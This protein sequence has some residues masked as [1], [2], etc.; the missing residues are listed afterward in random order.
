MNYECAILQVINYDLP[1]GIDDYVH[2]IGRTGR[3][4][5]P[6]LATSFYDKSTDG[7]LA[8]DLVKVNLFVLAQRNPFVQ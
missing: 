3:V 6:G 8:K 2:R 4:G 1:Q 7:V 5:N